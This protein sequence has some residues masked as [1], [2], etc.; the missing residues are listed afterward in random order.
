MKNILCSIL[1]LLLVSPLFANRGALLEDNFMLLQEADS[2]SAIKDPGYRPKV[3][4]VLCGGGAKGAAHVGVIKALEESGVEIDMVVGTSIGGI[5]GGLYAMGYNSHK[6]D[7]LF[8]NVDWSYLLSN[9]VPRKD[10]SFDKKQMDDMY[11]FKLPFATLY[12]RNSKEQRKKMRAESDNPA[13]A[14]FPAGLVNGQNVFNLLT[15]LSGGYQ[16]S[17][18]FKKDLPVPFACVAT[19]LS[20]GDQ[21]ILDK[22][23]M[24][25]AIRATM[26]IPGYFTPVTIDG[27]VLVDGGMVNNFPTDVAR[28]MGAD[29]IIGV[30]IQNDLRTTEELNSLPQIFNQIIGLMGNDRFEANLKLADVLVK[31]DVTKYGM[32]SFTPN[33]IDSLII[34]GYVAGV[35]AKGSFAHIAQLQQKYPA[36]GKS[37]KYVPARETNRQSY[38]IGEIVV[39]GVSESDAVWLL[40]KAGLKENTLLSG[41]NINSAIDVFYGTGAFSSVSYKLQKTKIGKDRLILDFVKGPANI[42]AV[43]ARFDSEEAA[44]IL[45]HLGIHTRDLF[46]SRLAITTRLSYNAYVKADYSYIFKSFPKVNLSYMFKSTDMNIYDKGVFSDYMS[47]NYNKVEASISNIYL[48]NFDFSGGVRYES[49]NYKHYLSSADE[50]TKDDLDAE[51]FLSYFVNTRMDSRDKRIFPSRGMA[52]DAEVVF[53]QSGFNKG[54]SFFTNLKLNVS[55][56][57]P[58]TDRL[59]MLPSLF[60]RSMI[61]DEKYLPYMNYAGGSEYGRYISQQIPFVGINYADMFESNIIVGRIDLRGRIGNKHYLYGI[62]N[63]MR[64]GESFDYLFNDHGRGHWG[65]G[66]K[67]AYETPLGPISANCHWSDYNNKVGFYLNLGYYF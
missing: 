27:K 23:Y 18:D 12:D 63:Y 38:R 53:F 39:N 66:I 58:L 30:D 11:L 21:V 40:R 2:T 10:L 49:F 35:A 62:V 15:T 52:F 42:L 57:I 55:G 64:N 7:S 48:R 25:S 67:Y 51:N 28:S 24:P 3:A 45:L 32:F 34:N 8:R 9:S 44:A 47:Y 46:G 37:R 41:E 5:V 26:A 54:N 29:I 6:M 20:T 19:D 43:G 13:T 65:V 22:G 1:A 14:Q 50:V 36:V 60:Y 4:L 61:G 17:I 33:A 16:D 59:T 56:A 31:P